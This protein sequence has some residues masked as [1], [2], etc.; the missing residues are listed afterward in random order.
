MLI[1]K[2]I[3]YLVVVLNKNLTKT[4]LPAAHVNSLFNTLRKTAC[5]GEPDYY[6]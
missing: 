3:V 5:L 6:L 2:Y 4:P 1:C